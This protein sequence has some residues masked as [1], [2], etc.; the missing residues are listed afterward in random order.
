MG[1]PAREIL[2]QPLPDFSF[3]ILTLRNMVE[4]LIDN[5]TKPEAFFTLFVGIHWPD[6]KFRREDRPFAKLYEQRANGIPQL[7][8]TIDHVVG[9][10]SLSDVK[11]PRIANESLAP[12]LSLKNAPHYPHVVDRKPHLI[13]DPDIAAPDYRLELNCLSNA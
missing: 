1:T 4:Q 11:D 12:P 6:T 5:E 3:R 8:G 2:P 10:L 13:L 9:Q 7:G